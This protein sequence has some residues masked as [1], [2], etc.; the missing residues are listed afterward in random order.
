MRQLEFD[1]VWDG[2]KKLQTTI[3]TDQGNELN[4]NYL[5]L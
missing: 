2:I 5:I 4:H 1:I 3:F